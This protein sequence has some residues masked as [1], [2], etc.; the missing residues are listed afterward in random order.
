MIDKV[1]VRYVIPYVIHNVRH[2]VAYVSSKERHITC[3]ELWSAY[4]NYLK[5]NIA[6][7]LLI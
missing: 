3:N 4:I 2:V 6:H 7:L 5:E 1:R